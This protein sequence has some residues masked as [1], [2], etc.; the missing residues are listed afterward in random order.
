MFA[1][2]M[3]LQPHPGV[4]MSSLDAVPSEVFKRIIKIS[5]RHSPDV[6]LIHFSVHNSSS[7][8]STKVTAQDLLNQV[9][10]S[11]YLND[12]ASDHVRIFG[13]SMHNSDIDIT[14]KGLIAE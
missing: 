4:E 12:I 14:Y 3:A 11:K 5:T 7:T 2:Y 1:L 6:I 9:Q 10:T 8:S 13:I